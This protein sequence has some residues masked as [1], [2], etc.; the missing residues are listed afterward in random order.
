MHVRYVGPFAAGVT[1]AATGQHCAPG[2]TIEVP[3]SL[4]RS[5]CRQAVWE[6]A[7]GGKP[8]TTQEDDD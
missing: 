8:A 7:P 4:G 6:K 1:I 2:D 3:D 5:L